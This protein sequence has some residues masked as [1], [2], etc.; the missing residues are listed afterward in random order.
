MA[1]GGIIVMTSK[2]LNRV[3]VIHNVINKQMT[4][5]E[6]ADILCLSRRQVIRLTAKVKKEGNE[7]L[8][9]KG[10]GSRSSRSKP[11]KLKAKILEICKSKYKGFSPSFASEKLFEIDKISIHHDTLRKWFIEV[12]IPYKK[13]RCREHRSWRERKT[14]FG[15]MVQLDGSHHQWFGEECAWSVLMGYVDDATSRVYLRFYEYEGTIPAM[16]SLKRYIKKNGIPRSVYLDKHTTYK[17]TKKPTIEDELKNIKAM[18]QFERALKEL[19][20]KVIHAD[21]P[22]AKGRVERSFR[23]H[24]DRLI[25]ELSLAG[26]KDIESANKFLDSYYIPKH[27]R[28]FSIAAKDLANMHRSI[29]GGMDIDRILCI[30]RT[31]S[32]R[33]DFTVQ[34]N[35]KYYQVLEAIG[36]KQIT[37]EEGLDGKIRLYYKDKRLKHKIIAKK[38]QRI[39][40]KKIV[41]IRKERY[42]LPADHPYRKQFKQFFVRKLAA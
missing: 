27:N 40:K 26:I 41:I 17:S 10:R 6:A 11:D 42:K 30:K 8:I 3:P 12:D 38:P 5:E 2:E 18:S 35:N 39:E 4:Q 25:K 14:F 34:Y 23:T 13:R 19:G 37:V 31:V 9:H 1:M 33:N 32:L 28:K 29:P 22:Q 36:A 15:M 21:S 7:G 24:Q 20:V 16:D